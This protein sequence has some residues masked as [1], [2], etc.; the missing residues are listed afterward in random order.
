MKDYVNLFYS[1]LDKI[2]DWENIETIDKSKIIS[3]FLNIKEDNDFLVKYFD[4]YNNFI[5]KNPL[6]IFS[7]DI[8]DLKI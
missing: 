8:I 6:K 2:H 4:K 1:I 5:V 3:F 7:K